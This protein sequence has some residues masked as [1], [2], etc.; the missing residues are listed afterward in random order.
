MVLASIH[1][2]KSHTKKFHHKRKFIDKYNLLG[3][4]Q[5][6]EINRIDKPVPFILKPG[7]FSIHHGNILHGSYENT[8]SAPR[9]LFAMR[10]ASYE[11]RSK[12][13]KYANYFFETNNYKKNFIELPRCNKDYDIKCLNYR[14]KL[15]KD[16]INLQLK[17]K[18]KKYY[19]FLIP[20]KFLILNKVFRKL[21]YIF[22]K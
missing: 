16:A 9:A 11:N 15:I 4:N 21:I 10:Y 22:L 1:I 20:I 14:E 7:E 6:V 18:A 19:K 3:S 5:N 17:L 13:Y 12:I 8:V 2:P